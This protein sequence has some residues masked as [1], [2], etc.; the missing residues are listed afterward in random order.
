MDRNWWS[1]LFLGRASPDA[2]QRSAGRQWL[3]WWG[4]GSLFLAVAVGVPILILGTYNYDQNLRENGRAQIAQVTEVDATN[5]GARFTVK[6]DGKDVQL[7]NPSLQPKV[8]DDIGVVVAIDGRVVLADDAGARDKATG[9]AGFAVFLAFLVLIVGGWGPGLAPY[10]AVKSVRVPELLKQSTI[11]T[12]TAVEKVRPPQG[13]VYG[14]WRRGT[15]AFYDLDLRMPDKRT[16]RWQGRL[17][18]P[19]AVNS[20]ASMVGGGFPG[21]WV[22][23]LTNISE[24][25]AEA[26]NWPAVPLAEPTRG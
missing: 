10:R 4:C 15:G 18:K 9:D 19:P 22:V 8:G 7:S 26:V 21:D 24:S 13:A 20:K 17:A 12:F 16:A 1:R 3:R 5:A 2:V 11:V 23:L 14:A 6:V 25:D